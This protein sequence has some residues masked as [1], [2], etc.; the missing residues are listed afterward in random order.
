MTG[1]DFETIRYTGF[2]DGHQAKRAGVFIPNPHMPGSAA[3]EHYEDGYDLGVL[4]AKIDMMA[5]EKISDLGV[6]LVDIH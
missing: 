5:E 3:F 4:A 1:V 2:E 6:L